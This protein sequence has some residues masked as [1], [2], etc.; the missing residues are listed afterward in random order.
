MK[1]SGTRRALAL[2]GELRNAI[3]FVGVIGAAA[4]SV[5]IFM[6]WLDNEPLAVQIAGVALAFLVALLALAAANRFIYQPRWPLHPQTP[7]VA[8]PAPSGDTRSPT[9][10]RAQDDPANR[11]EWVT[12]SAC[13]HTFQVTAPSNASIV[14]LASLELGLYDTVEYPLPCPSCGYR[15]WV[16][17][18]VLFH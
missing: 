9:V 1:I 17:S 16:R 4:L 7:P 15:W 2:Y 13:A 6:I 11:L 12:C 3:E 14:E 5:L 18:T 8:P 10:R